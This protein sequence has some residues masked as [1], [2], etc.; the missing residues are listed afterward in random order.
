MKLKHKLE[1]KPLKLA[2]ACVV[3][4]NDDVLNEKDG[5]ADEAPKPPRPVPK[6]LNAVGA[7]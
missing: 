6:P 4:P 2:G 3:A 1:P 7:G 5:A